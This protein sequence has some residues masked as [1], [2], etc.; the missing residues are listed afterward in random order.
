MA[1][2]LNMAVAS[3][4]SLG[5]FANKRART[6]L[7]HFVRQSA[8]TCKKVDVDEV[9]DAHGFSRLSERQ[10]AAKERK[11]DNQAG[12]DHDSPSDFS[13]RG[14]DTIRAVARSTGYTSGGGLHESRDQRGYGAHRNRSP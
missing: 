1:Y 12:S 2:N 7:D 5:A 8:R 9:H 11:S 10:S 4:H 3:A 13:T 14:I 6:Y